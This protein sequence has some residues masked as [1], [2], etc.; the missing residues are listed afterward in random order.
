MMTCET[1]GQ[2]DE[3]ESGGPKKNAGLVSGHAYSLI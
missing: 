1:S 3:T 2:D